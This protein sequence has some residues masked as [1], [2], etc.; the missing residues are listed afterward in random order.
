MIGTEFVLPISHSIR[1]QI[2]EY[3][4]SAVNEKKN[5]F[6][7][8]SQNSSS[9]NKVDLNNYLRDIYNNDTEWQ[10]DVKQISLEEIKKFEKKEERKTRHQQRRK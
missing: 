6:Q 5:Y 10:P 9:K 7:R 4:K 1:E 8:Y 3:Q 2:L